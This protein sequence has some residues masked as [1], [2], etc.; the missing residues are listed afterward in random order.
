MAKVLCTGTL[1]AGTRSNSA[2]LLPPNVRFWPILLKNSISVDEEGMRALQG[3]APSFELR[4]GHT[5]ELLSRPRT[6]D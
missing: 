2:S 3:R 1:V 4:G 5:D 6:S